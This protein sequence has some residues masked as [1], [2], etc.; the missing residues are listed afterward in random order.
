[1]IDQKIKF[2]SPTIEDYLGIIYTLHRDGQEVH[3]ARLAEL[4]NVSSPT[5]SVT[6]QRMVRDKWIILNQEKN[7]RLTQAG[8]AAASSII[9]RHMLTEWMLSKILNISW[10]ELHSEA[11]KIEHVISGDVEKSLI[12]TLAD[13]TH[14]PHGNPMPGSEEAS[15]SWEPLSSF[16]VDDWL[17]IRRIHEFLES[18]RDL[19]KYLEINNVVPGSIAAITEIMPFN[20]NMKLKIA[21]LSVILGFDVANNIYVEKIK[22]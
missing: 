16:L 10:S 6:L 9:R 11:D 12:E 5:V 8:L 20:K 19:M 15:E 13:P 21:D 7:I 4:L 2:P 1:L 17:I 22:G 14:C 3:G 18:D